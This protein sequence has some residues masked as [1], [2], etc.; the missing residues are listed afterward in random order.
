MLNFNLIE[1]LLLRWDNLK[2][3][4]YLL[5]IPLI[6]LKTFLMFPSMP[7]LCT[8]NRPRFSH[9]LSYISDH[10]YHLSLDCS[11]FVLLYLTLYS[12]KD[13]RLYCKAACVRNAFVLFFHDLW[14][15]SPRWSQATEECLHPDEKSVLLLNH[16]LYV[17][18]RE[19]IAHQL[20]ICNNSQG[21]H[22]NDL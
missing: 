5:K 11:N 8:Q 22:N 2:H 12:D 10:F 21:Y 6:I 14:I 16:R 15:I 9:L 1:E 17:G 7:H 3:M 18:E 20:R 19:C 4:I 13:R